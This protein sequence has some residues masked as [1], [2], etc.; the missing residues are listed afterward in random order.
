MK[1]TTVTLTLGEGDIRYVMAYYASLAKPVPSEHMMFFAETGS[2]TISI[3]KKIDKEGKRKVVFQGMEAEKESSIFSPL[4]K[5]T[6]TVPF[7]NTRKTPY[8]FVSQIG[9]DEV[10]TGDFFGP[11]VVCAAYVGEDGIGRLR[12][13]G[14]TD[15]KKM[16][17][18]YILQIGAELSLHYDHSLLVLR[19][20]RYNE[21]FAS[22][23]NMNAIKAK[24][25]NRCLGIVSSRHPSA[26]LFQDQFAEEGLYYHY[27]RRDENIVRNIT[28]AT[29]GETKFPSVALASVIARYAFLVHMQRMGK[30][31]GAPIPFGAGP[32]VD[33]F[34]KKILLAK[35]E[36]YLGKFVKKNFANFKKIIS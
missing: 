34:A 33:Q 12:E 20:E 13:L 16:N 14:V 21:V 32:A 10:G 31:L 36:D 29:K 11:I 8:R 35:G 25:H 15:S 26:R 28:F 23:L 18:E 9:S 24:M 3:Y 19:N 1:S 27:L 4:P 22:G 30:E 2:C 17:D 7:S 6:A 5:T